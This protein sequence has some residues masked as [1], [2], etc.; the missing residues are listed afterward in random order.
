MRRAQPGD[1]VLLLGKGHET[2]I[3]YGAEPRPWD[4]A[5]EARRALAALGYGREGA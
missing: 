4:E 1:A 2:S 5:A 3:I